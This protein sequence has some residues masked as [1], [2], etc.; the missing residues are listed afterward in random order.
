MAKVHSFLNVWQLL[1]DI[2]DMA[3][4]VTAFWR[5]NYH[6]C[7][8]GLSSTRAALKMN[9]MHRDE[10]FRTETNAFNAKNLFSAYTEQRSTHQTPEKM[11]I[12]C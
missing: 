9:Y 4:Y 3:M 7:I 5:K 10:V 1:D 2:Q 11:I 8:P 6:L 12:N